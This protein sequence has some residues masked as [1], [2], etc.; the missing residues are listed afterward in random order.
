MRELVCARVAVCVT[1]CPGSKE[2]SSHF[3]AGSIHIFQKVSF[4]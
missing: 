4:R 2:S 1:V 3:P